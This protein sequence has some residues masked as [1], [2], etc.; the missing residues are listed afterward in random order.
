MRWFWGCMLFWKHNPNGSGRQLQKYFDDQNRI[1]KHSTNLK[2]LICRLYTKH[3]L[4]SKSIFFS[5]RAGEVKS[6][7]TLHE[8]NRLQVIY[9]PSSIIT[10]S[11]P[12]GGSVYLW[13]KWDR[14][15]WLNG[16]TC[17]NHSEYQAC[18]SFLPASN[19]IHLMFSKKK[20]I[21]S[22]LHCT[23]RRLM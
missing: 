14:Q 17:W 4:K 9:L 8:H 13:L 16:I 20:P 1:R 3:V 2:K 22:C 11:L 23:T 15:R 12:M 18:S 10:F 7:T 5:F 19:N 6:W 21:L